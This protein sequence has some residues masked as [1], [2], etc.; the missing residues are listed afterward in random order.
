M[1]YDERFYAMIRGLADVQSVAGSRVYHVE[2]VMSTGKPFAKYPAVV[3]QL[4]ADAPVESLAGKSG[5]RV[6]SFSVML[7]SQSTADL[8]TLTK[9]INSVDRSVPACTANGFEWLAVTD[10][11]DEYVTP[12]EFDEKAMKW[13]AMEVSVTYREE[14]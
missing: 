8:R 14:P 1:T 13:A 10:I 7:F 3:Y 6:A 2:V 11:S 5:L 12:F 9:A 4:N